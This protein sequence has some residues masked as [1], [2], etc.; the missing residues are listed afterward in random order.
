MSARQ[1]EATNVQYLRGA[2]QAPRLRRPGV[3]ADR[4]RRGRRA[5][6]RCA[7]AAAGELRAQLLHLS[8]DISKRCQHTA[9]AVGRPTHTE[10]TWSDLKL[11]KPGS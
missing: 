4:R 8:E 1:C 10:G 9:V 3:R 11:K 7:A 5:R 6:Q 2:V